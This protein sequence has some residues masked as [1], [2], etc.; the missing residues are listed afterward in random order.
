MSENNNKNSFEINGT[1]RKIYDI[2]QISDRL[3]KRE[4]ILET[5]GEYPQFLKFEL[6]NSNIS[7]LQGYNE[8]ISVLVKFNLNGRK[9]EK[10]GK[11]L[12]FNSLNAWFVQ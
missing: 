6:V 10:D 11:S 4:F 2:E 12:V 3:K 1:I 5:E 9:Y 8:G 7:K